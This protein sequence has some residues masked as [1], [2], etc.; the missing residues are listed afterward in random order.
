VKN[1]VSN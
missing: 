1:P